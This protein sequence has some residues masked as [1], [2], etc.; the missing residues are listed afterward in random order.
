MELTRSLLTEKAKEYTDEEPLYPVE[1]EAIE[2]YPSAFSEGDFG[3]RDTE[4]VVQWHYRRFLGA[5]PDAEHRAGEKEF[6]ENEFET[7]RE[8]IADV[9]ASTDLNERIE[10]LIELEGINLPV[11][12]AFLQYIDP[13]LYLV[14]DER[15]WGVLRE[16]G[17]LDDPYPDAPSVDEY[18]EFLDTCR[19][20]SE[21]FDVDLWTLYRALW[22]L[23][24]SEW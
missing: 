13:E 23:D 11:A 21:E 22:R 14:I 16:V 6:G 3:W 1:A 9:V 17:K 5:Y 8:V 24:R 15:T 20:T 10:G 18:R 4:W 19:R 2:M 7:V 12:T